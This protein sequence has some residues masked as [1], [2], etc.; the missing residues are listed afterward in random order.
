MPDAASTRAAPTAPTTSSTTLAIGFE[1]SA[2]KISVGVV[3]ADGTILANPRE[4]YVT[5]PGTGF[6]PRETAKHH[7]DVV[8]ELAR[9]GAGGG[10]S[11]DA[12]RGRGVLHARAGD[13]GAADD[14]G[15]V[16]EDAGAA[17][18]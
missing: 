2:N 3:R 1:G 17:V 5:P 9:R 4:T 10:E 12:R 16:R 6:L 18:R 11:V 14:G 7:R 8:V 15:G 13:G